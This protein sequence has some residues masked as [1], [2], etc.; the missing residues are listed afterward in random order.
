MET[1]IKKCELDLCIYN[2][3]KECTLDHISLDALS[4]CN[5]CII[6]TIPDKILDKLKL[7]TLRRLG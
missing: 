2:K 1:K 6:P 5:S 7:D 4:M 3:D